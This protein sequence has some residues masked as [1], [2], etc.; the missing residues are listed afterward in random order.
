MISSSHRVPDCPTFYPTEQQW[1]D[2]PFTYIRNVVAPAAQGTAGI[3]KVVPPAAWRP[4][5]CLPNRD[6]FSFTPRVQVLNALEATVRAQAQFLVDLR[7]FNF[8]RGHPLSPP[9]PVRT[10]LHHRVLPHALYASFLRVAR[11]SRC[12]A[13]YHACLCVHMCVR[14]S[15][16]VLCIALQCS[17]L[18]VLSQK[19]DGHELDL[20]QLFIFVVSH[21]GYHAVS[22]AG[23]WSQ[24]LTDLCIPARLNKKSK[25][26]KVSKSKSKKPK[27]KKAKKPQHATMWESDTDSAPDE[28][29]SDEDADAASASVD[30]AAASESTS[31]Q[32][33]QKWL[34]RHYLVWLLAYEQFLFPHMSPPDAPLPTAMKSEPVEVPPVAAPLSQDALEPAQQDDYPS[35]VQPSPHDEFSPALSALSAVDAAVTVS[36]DASDA[37]PTATPDDVETPSTSAERAEGPPSHD[38]PTPAEPA[39]AD[40]DA[41]AAP[42]EVVG[43]KRRRKRRTVAECHPPLPRTENLSKRER[44][45]PLRLADEERFNF[46]VRATGSRHGKAEREYDSYSSDGDD[47]AARVHERRP[48][49]LPPPDQLVSNSS[50]KFRLPIRRKAPPTVKVGMQFYRYFQSGESSEGRV[51]QSLVFVLS[52]SFFNVLLCMF[53][54]ICYSTHLGHQLVCSYLLQNCREV[55]V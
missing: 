36:T 29:L 14:A 8:A 51:S 19:I 7:I 50:G 6:T 40:G 25:W 41:A 30:A 2:D 49:V 38:E 27:K 52:R 18:A 42:A 32:Q 43:G 47:A 12:G 44:K 13:V 9:F 34:K 31:S 46:D 20:R 28:A 39:T 48:I 37:V 21:G 24:V 26:G 33:K 53:N 35:A 1:K 15:V 17:L 45:A 3:A 23:L 11:A 5:F 4:P 54:H 10:C 16:C 55:L 22:N